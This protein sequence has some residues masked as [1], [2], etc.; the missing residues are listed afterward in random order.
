M[1]LPQ[2]VQL[3]LAVSTQQPVL[4]T[5]LVY[6]QVS[7]KFLV[8][9]KCT[10]PKTEKLALAHLLQLQSKI[11]KEI[12]VKLKYIIIKN[13]LYLHPLVSTFLLQEYVSRLL[14]PLLRAH[15]I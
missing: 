5:L 3:V 9:N 7:L 1:L 10:Y 6:H 2:V 14:Q 8:Q 4:V 11:L 12:I 15:W 13:D